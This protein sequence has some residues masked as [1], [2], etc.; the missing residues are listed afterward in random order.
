MPPITCSSPTYAVK[1]GR[2]YR[3]YISKRLVR[4][5]DQNNGWRL[6]AEEL[7]GRVEG[8]VCDLLN[9]QMRLIKV[10]QIP[11]TS[12]RQIRQVL[13][14]AS[15]LAKRIG[16]DTTTEKTRALQ[17]LIERINIGPEG[18]QISIS[19][20]RLLEMVGD[21]CRELANDWPSLEKV[22]HRYR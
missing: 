9:D 16:A 15:E 17:E 1:T 5:A 7:E 14:K 22:V 12:P 3:Y 18:I 4:E 13:S 11:S 6:P 8:E 20:R 10:V 21:D 19:R 2:R